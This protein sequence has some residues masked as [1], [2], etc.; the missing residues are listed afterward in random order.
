ML[1]YLDLTY[2][3]VLS[4]HVH[5]HSKNNY[6][7]FECPPFLIARYGIEDIDL[8]LQTLL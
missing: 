6:H 7:Y 5:F 2:V 8:G 1:I 3:I 4:V